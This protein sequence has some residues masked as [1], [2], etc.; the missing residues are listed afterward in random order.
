MKCWQG[1]ES[2]G[3]IKQAIEI[4]DIKLTVQLPVIKIAMKIFQSSSI[5]I[6]RKSIQVAQKVNLHRSETRALNFREIWKRKT[7]FINVIKN[8]PLN[9][10][11]AVQVPISVA[12]AE[13][14]QTHSKKR[15]YH[16]CKMNKI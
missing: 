5:I 11:D 2:F 7:G 15:H 16:F 13:Q 8:Y 9:L 6:M 12:A 4:L 3:N 10:L 1:D 14:F